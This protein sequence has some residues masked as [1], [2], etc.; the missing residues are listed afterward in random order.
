MK[1]FRLFLVAVFLCSTVAVCLADNVT[2]PKPVTSTTVASA[3]Y[4]IDAVRAAHSDACPTIVVQKEL[5][6]LVDKDGGGACPLSAG[7]IADQVIRAM[8]GIP[9]D[10]QPHRSALRIFQ[11][12]PEL[13]EGRISN[14]RFE[15]LLQDLAVEIS[16]V[17]LEVEVV[18]AP[19]SKHA[20][21]DDAQFWSS[22]G[23]DLDLQAGALK[24]LAYTVTTADGVELGRHFVLL[25]DSFGD[26]IR[27]LNPNKPLKDY[28][29]TVETQ[30]TDDASP[31][32]FFAASGFTSTQELNTIFL[33]N[34]NP[35]DKTVCT[36]SSPTIVQIQTEI[37]AL[38]KQLSEE[39]KLTD[40]REW[41]KRGAD[42]GLPG[43]DLPIAAGGGGFSVEQ[44]VEVFRH[45]GRHNLNLR[46]VVGGAHG[47]PAVKMNSI[48]AQDAVRSL[49]TGDAYFAVAI[50]EEDAGTHT[51]N[52]Q[53]RAESDGDG[54][55][56]TGSKLWNARLQ[57]ATHVV[58]YTRAASGEGDKQSAF[59]LPIDH[60][61]LEIINRYAHGLTGN[62]FGGLNFENMYVGAEHLIGRD[63][64]GGELFEEHF[65]YWRLM[66][67][68]AAIG[69]GE[70]ALEIMAARIR[71]RQVFGGPIARF[72]HLQQPLGEQ[73]TK[74]QM[75]LA[76][77]REAARH[78]DHGNHDVAKPLINGLKAEG[79]EIA[80]DACDASMRA[81][82]ALGY[83]RDVDLGDR[84]RDL[85]GLRI[86]DGTTDVMRMTV[87]RDVYGYDLWNTAVN[88]EMESNE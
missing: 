63:G 23:P 87:V 40:P 60:P 50:T 31:R 4:A 48:V 83:S 62:S 82:G 74:L 70:R 19:N 16:G 28:S 51:K 46:D 38:A 13:K 54:F 47:R 59:L 5:D 80:L 65:Q 64:D 49:V 81:H 26:Q 86:A 73:F 34:V 56:L 41:R 76:L 22:D 53:S 55:R 27:V 43:L 85:M 72:T 52:M 17:N 29:F 68:A 20:G 71:D 9:L 24:V 18:S 61:G 33:I 75:S 66:Q 6:R 11:Q 2:R 15:R 35:D 3:K 8:A 78:I 88:V 14:D 67:A 1:T 36:D 37:D 45:A 21:N 39:G 7:L 57:Q 44:M 10:P 12:R 32:V 58:L 69:C 30:F 79:V 77:A 42:F 84:V 25:R